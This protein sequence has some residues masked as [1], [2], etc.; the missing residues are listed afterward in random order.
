MRTCR[1]ADN[2]PCA[3]VTEMP[4]A[5]CRNGYCSQHNALIGNFKPHAVCEYAFFRIAGRTPHNVIILTFH[6]KR[7]RR[8]AVRDKVYPKQMHGFKYRE[9]QER[10]RKDA[11]HLTR[12][13]SKQELNR[14][15]DVVVNA[16]ALFNGGNDSCKIIV[17]KHHIGNIF[18]NIRARDAH[19]HADIG[20]FDGSC[21]VHAV[22]GHCGNFASPLP[23]LDNAHLVFGLHA[24]I[25][26]ILVNI[27]VKLIIGHF[28]QLR[29]RQRFGGIGNDSE[30]FCN[31]NRRIT[32]VTGYH[33]GTDPRLAAFFDGRYR[34]RANRV[35]HAGNSDVC[36]ILFEI[37]RRCDRGLFVPCP[38]C[39][40]ECTQCIIRHGFVLRKYFTAQR[41]RHRHDFAAVEITRAAFEQFIRRT[42]CELDYFPVM[43]VNGGHKLS[44]AVERSFR[45]AGVFRLQSRFFQSECGCKIHKRTFRRFADRFLRFVGFRIGTERHRR[46]KQLFVTARGAHNR[47]SVLGQRACF[48]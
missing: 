44:H 15:A 31:C 28:V 24:G 13:G 45:N 5:V 6:C 14:L 41:I 27:I 40:S 37:L 25:H 9:A 39:R 1:A 11:Q 21:I 36:K 20:C 46:C 47:H 8:E 2:V 33:D 48:I 4:D 42:L 16:P 12:I 38:H 32:V 19:A 3:E 30:L 29:A 22:A 10:C 23:C 34:F 7:K 18:C 26:R 35:Y 43:V 17:R